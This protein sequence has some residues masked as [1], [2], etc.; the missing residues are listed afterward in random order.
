MNNCDSLSYHIV[1][2]NVT[3]LNNVLGSIAMIARLK[4]RTG[5][6]YVIYVA[7]GKAKITTVMLSV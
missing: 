6:N 4:Y 1:L 3:I 5:C 2:I 7:L